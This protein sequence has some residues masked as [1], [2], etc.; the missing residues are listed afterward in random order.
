MATANI[1][2]TACGS[3]AT[4]QSLYY[5]STLIATGNP[6]S[7]TGWT[8]YSGSTLANSVSSQTITSLNDNVDYTF[9]V[10]CNC[11]S[12]NGPLSTIGPVIKNVCPTVGTITPTY[13][14]L[15]YTV[16]VPSSAN[17]A[18]SWIQTIVVSVLNSAGTTTLQSTTFNAPFN[19]TL[20]SNFTGLNS[21]TNYSLA[22]SYGQTSG[23]R[24]NSCGST[25]FTTAAAC[26]TPSITVSNITSNS[27]NVSWTPTT[28]GSFDILLN[29]T[30]VATGLTSTNGTY[31]VTGLTTATIYQVAVRLNCTTGGTGISTT[32]NVTTSSA[33]LNGVV[34]ISQNTGDGSQSRKGLTM[35]FQFP[36]ATAFPITINFGQGMFY[37][38][39]TEAYW[40][41]DLF[42][43]PPAGAQWPMYSNETTPI[44]STFGPGRN[45]PWVVTIPQGVTT[46]TTTQD[47][48]YTAAGNG[49]GSGVPGNVGGFN[50][51]P[52]C[53]PVN[54]GGLYIAD[55]WLRVTSPTGYNANFTFT[56]GSNVGD[57]TIHNV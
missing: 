38:G 25:P 41:Y 15:S 9:Y 56:P 11:T 49:G 26:A 7:G 12:G 6:L 57:I 46:Y 30:A 16:N 37:Y 22:I 47:A 4:S 54:F 29:G 33:V 32:Q 27:F 53:V 52:W 13:N 14:G 31:T 42:T 1:S 43:L 45:S 21:A 17:N 3:A 19:A 51:Q 48:I 39:S 18:G 24:T 8:L 36:Q 2:W 20:S 5:G 40:G 35:S 23:S 10:F 34:S 55:I 50:Y 28:G 44:G